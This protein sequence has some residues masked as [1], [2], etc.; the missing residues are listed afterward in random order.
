M[1]TAAP[2]T[3]EARAASRAIFGY[4]LTADYLEFDAAYRQKHSRYADELEQL[5]TELARQ[6]VHGRA[7]PCSRQIFLEAGWLTFHSAHWQRIEARLKD[8]REMLARPADPPEARQQVAADGS[9]DHCSGAWF[10]KLDSTIEEVEDHNER[11][12][13][14]QH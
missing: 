13:P 8:L 11:G 6:A 10:L 4:D 14:I 5:Q 7:T 9:F 1:A 3:S 12:A 2:M